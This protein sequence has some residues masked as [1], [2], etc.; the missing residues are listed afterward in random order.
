MFLK[1][2]KKD[3]STILF[4]TISLIV[5]VIVLGSFFIFK[6]GL[7]LLSYEMLVEKIEK[8]YYEIETEDPF[9]TSNINL[10]NKIIKPE[11][12]EENPTLGQKDAK[13]N[14]VYFSDYE[15]LSCHKQKNLIEETV[16]ESDGKISLTWKDYPSM[17][18]ESL[19]WKVAVATRC[20]GMQNKFWSYQGKLFNNFDNLDNNKLIEL[21]KDMDMSMIEFAKCV[22]NDESEE[23]IRKDLVEANNLE[24]IGVPFLFVGDQEIMGEF[25]KKELE[26]LI[27]LELKKREGKD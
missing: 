22:R 4:V 20:A 9:I 27:Q 21:G 16:K 24:I 26:Y 8:P 18:K 3:F 6:Y 17:D 12:G 2:K 13:I 11:V 15:C 7:N 10:Q 5:F 23:L 25:Q 14:L 19:S 1:F